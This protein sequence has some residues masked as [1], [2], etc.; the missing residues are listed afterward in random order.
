MPKMNGIEATAQITSK[1]SNTIIIGLSV[2]ANA[3]YQ[4]M[5]KRAGAIGLIQK[6]EAAERLYEAIHEA[7]KR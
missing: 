4:E 7:V 6:E 5:M 3:P 1:Y 2:N